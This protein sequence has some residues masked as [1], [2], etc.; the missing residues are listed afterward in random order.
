[1]SLVVDVPRTQ[2]DQAS[3]TYWIPIFVGLAVLY[4]PTFWSLSNSIWQTEEQGHGPI[5]LAIVGWIIWRLR[6]EFASIVP[7]PAPLAGWTM[8]TAGL[9][10]YVLGRS[11][12]IWLFEVGSQIAVG[13]GILLVAFGWAAVRSAWFPLFFLLF[14]VPVPGFIIDA[15]TGPLKQHVSAIAETILYA[16]GYPIARSGVVLTIGQY[17]L[18]VADACSGLNSMFSLSALG[19]L[20][21]H[22]SREDRWWKSAVLLASVLPTAFAANIVRVVILVLIT[23]HLG[24]EAGQGFIHGFAGM[25]LFVIAL[26][27]LFGID[28]LLQLFGRKSLVPS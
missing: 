4:L 23:Y 2:P 5:I 6:S 3:L 24:D 18:L 1:M 26:V 7:A 12:D 8:L 9:V 13:A 16:A 14:M 10:A 20:Y 15:L 19:V 28:A 22:L 17:Q 21:V 25:I 27:I 11:Q